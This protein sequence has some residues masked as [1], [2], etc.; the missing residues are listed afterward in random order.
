MNKNCYFAGLMFFSGITSVSGKTF[1]NKSTAPGTKP[2][3]LFIIT[4]QQAASMLS[5]GGN[6]YVKTPNL[7]KLSDSGVRFNRA[8]A[9]NPVSVPSRFSMMTGIMP[10]Q[11]NAEA[12]DL[13]KKGV[14]ENVLSGAL[15]VAFKN[16]GYETVYGGKI[17]LPGISEETVEDV[18]L[19]GFKNISLDYRG[20]LAQTCADYIKQKHDSPFIMVA[21]FMNPHDICYMAVNAWNVARNQKQ[22]LGEPWKI[23]QDALKIPAGMS[24]DTFFKTVCPPLPKNFEVPNGELPEAVGLNAAFMKYVREK[25]GEREWRLHRWAYKNLTELVDKEI[26][27]VLKALEDSKNENNT[28]VVF[29]SD[30]GD[31]DASHRLEHKGVFYEE[32]V[33]VPLILK[34]KGHINQGTVDNENLV[35]TGL[36]IFSTL[37]DFAEISKPTNL[38]GVS[39]KNIS[40][41]K[42]PNLKRE[43]IV[44]ET[45]NARMLLTKEWK[46]MV[47]GNSVKEEML[48]NLKT[49]PGEM[50]NLAQKP[51]YKKE[52]IKCRELLVKWYAEN[53]LLI[54]K[55]Y[56]YN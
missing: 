30:H 34:W 54:N 6:E 14:P 18:N 36:D 8:Y 42:N 43:Y 50:D 29:T 3:I 39:L 11:V 38:N 25:W 28:L 17:H 22:M 12:N 15:G 27:I 56:I 7:D 46:Y 47:S 5:C 45:K 40:I 16:A 35:M 20:K 13:L 24:E 26:G 4:D 51:Q 52:I 37:C 33:R 10:S 19:Y 21:S 31:M 2:N 48:F 53:N 41:G 49:D 55:K 1:L 9:T 32:S 44:S 23:L